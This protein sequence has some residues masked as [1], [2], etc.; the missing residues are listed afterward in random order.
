[1]SKTKGLLIGCGGL[2]LFGILI[3]A[4]LGIFVYLNLYPRPTKELVPDTAGKFKLEKLDYST[5]NIWGTVAS[6]SADYVL[7]DDASR[8]MDYHIQELR[9]AGEAQNI[10]EKFPCSNGTKAREILKDKTGKE[11][12][13]YTACY[14]EQF[15]NKD[16]GS[17]IF[18]NGK[19]WGFLGSQS[20]AGSP[21]L[22]FSEM[23]N[24]LAGLP[25][26]SETDFSKLET[27]GTSTSIPLKSSSTNPDETVLSGFDLDKQQRTS[28]E[29]VRQYNGKEIVV[30]GYVYSE[31]VPRGSDGGGLVKLGE[32]DVAIKDLFIGVSCWFEKEDAAAFAGVKSQY[33][34][35]KGTFDSRYSTELRYCRL[36]R[37]E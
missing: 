14:K 7:S 18:S 29:S 36:I 27:A 30:R 37:K 15:G 24:F 31:P 33:I 26:Y 23:N 3:A 6:F 21:Q 19:R 17:V 16:T 11:I 10:V 9:S 20:N 1:M 32:K 2:S 22:T 12:G 5:G 4:I 25:F 28:K 8:K 34:T 35:V 13:R